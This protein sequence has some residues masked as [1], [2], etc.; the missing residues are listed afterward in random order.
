MPRVLTRK[1]PGRNIELYF[2]DPLTGRER[3]QSSGTRDQREADR[4]AQKWEHKLEQEGYA[5]DM[6]WTPA[7]E[8]W[9]A[10]V[11]N[12]R[13]KSTYADYV[14]ALDLFEEMIGPTR[15]MAAITTLTLDRFV[16]KVR[17]AGIIKKNSTLALRLKGLRLFFRWCASRDIIAKVPLFPMPRI[18]PG[19]ETG[20]NPITSDQFKQLLALLPAPTQVIA[21]GMWLSGLR[22]GEAIALHWSEGLVVLHLDGPRSYIHFEPEGQKSRRREDMPLTK[23]FVEFLEQL[24][25]REGFVLN[26]A[27]RRRQTI[28]ENFLYAAGKL[29]FPVTP[30]LM[31]KS[32]ATRWAM[33]L[34][35]IELQALMRHKDIRVTLKYY[36]KFTRDQIQQGVWAKHAPADAPKSSASKS[37]PARQS[38][39]KRAKTSSRS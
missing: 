8:L 5:K 12:G 30:K 19:E 13:A 38:S 28:G 15:S 20:G 36:A 21:R 23:E 10:S 1:K 32:F 18:P 4:A 31:R 14:R 27:N 35:H 6:A 16:A 9:L 39:K 33:V 37:A 29:S 11:R 2:V 26:P 22:P 25:H 7:R 3:T 17:E 24:P 34:N